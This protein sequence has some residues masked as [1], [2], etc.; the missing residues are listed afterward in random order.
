VWLVALLATVLLALLDVAGAVAA[1]EWAQHRLPVALVA[2]LVLA[3]LLFLVY[4]ATLQYA[5]LTTVTF[6]WVVMLQVGVVLLDRF[7]YDEPMPAGTWVAVGVLI[8]A[9]AYLL[10]APAVQGRTT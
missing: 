7:R 6:G 1:K 2:G 5:S 9:Q 3:A 8:L 4:A 10:L